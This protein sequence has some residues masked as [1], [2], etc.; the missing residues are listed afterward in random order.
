MLVLA[1]VPGVVA[2]VAVA[3]VT[4]LAEDAGDAE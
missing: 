3:V 1:T 2:P 4:V